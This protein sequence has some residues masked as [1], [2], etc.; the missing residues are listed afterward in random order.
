MLAGVADGRELI[1]EVHVQHL[2]VIGQLDP[3]LPSVVEHGV[4]VVDVHHVGGL[5]ERVRKILVSRVEGMINLERA[6]ALGEVVNHV[7]VAGQVNEH[8]I[9]RVGVK[10][11]AV[12]VGARTAGALRSNGFA[13]SAAKDKQV[14]GITECSA[15]G[16]AG[17]NVY[18][19]G[20]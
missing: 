17:I 18:S 16:A 1:A 13:R 3:G 15:V 5:D 11:Q 7:H 4:P 14:R 12:P 2:E 9:G 10:I 20:K 8:A 6:A 19:I